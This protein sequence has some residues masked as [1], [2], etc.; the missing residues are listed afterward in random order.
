MRQINNYIK[1]DAY[2]DDTFAKFELLFARKN[3]LVAGAILTHVLLFLCSD[4]VC[5]LVF[6]YTHK[7][8][9]AASPCLRLVLEDQ[10]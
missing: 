9:D 6:F 2:R 7:A 4:L 8:N 1:L 5:C 3:M 10:A